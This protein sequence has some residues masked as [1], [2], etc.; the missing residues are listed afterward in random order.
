MTARVLLRHPKTGAIWACP[1]RAVDAW[2][3]KGWRRADGSKP[4]AARRRDTTTEE[5]SNG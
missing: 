3:A 2:L 4:T 5:M 1:A